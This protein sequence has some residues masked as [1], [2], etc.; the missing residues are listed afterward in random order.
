MKKR[1]TTRRHK[2]ANPQQKRR[3]SIKVN[4][5][6]PCARRRR[7]PSALQGLGII[8]DGV[9]AAFGGLGTTFVRGLIPIN[10]GGAIGEAA[11]QAGVAIGL[12]EL[13]ARFLNRE[14]G[15]MVTLGGVTVAATSLLQTYNLTP[16]A[17]LTPR[18][19]AK[20]AVPA[21]AGDFVALKNTTYDPYYG[22]T[23]GGMNG[24]RSGVG[25]FVSVAPQPR[26]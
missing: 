13:V 8:K 5:K 7:N 18:S 9:F 24:L 16:A 11:I 1:S 2:K 21:G 10:F 14:A 6:K 26:F 20:A 17:L 22:R 23:L 12:G 25:D 3:V 4:G 19:A 15:K